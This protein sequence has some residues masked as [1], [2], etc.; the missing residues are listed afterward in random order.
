MYFGN[1]I[2]NYKRSV[3]EAKS[4]SSQNQANSALE[5]PQSRPHQRFPARVEAPLRKLR[6]PRATLASQNP[7]KDPASQGFFFFRFG[8]LTSFSK[9]RGSV[10]KYPISAKNFSTRKFT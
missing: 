8:A 5:T 6:N 2:P 10:G 3:L 7:Y 1:R 9:E 4:Q